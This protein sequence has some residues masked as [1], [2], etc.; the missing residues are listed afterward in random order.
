MHKATFSLLPGHK[1]SP[2]QVAS[3]FVFIQLCWLL[4]CFFLFLFFSGSSRCSKFKIINGV[5]KGAGWV[6][7]LLLIFFLINKTFVD[8]K[9][10]TEQSHGGLQL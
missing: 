5:R 1:G 9:V 8:R 7:F 3:R 4:W 6:L 10:I 2:Q